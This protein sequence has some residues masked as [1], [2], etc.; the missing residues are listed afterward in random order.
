M[1]F[2]FSGG[3]DVDQSP[4]RAAGAFSP[5]SV[6]GASTASAA[7]ADVLGWN[8]GDHQGWAP[9]PADPAIAQTKSPR[10]PQCQEV[11]SKSAY[12]KRWQEHGGKD[13]DRTF[14]KHPGEA[15]PRRVP[16]NGCSP[17]PN[18]VVEEEQVSVSDRI[19]GRSKSQIAA[20]QDDG[21]RYGVA[22][23]QLPDINVEHVDIDLPK[24]RRFGEFSPRNSTPRRSPIPNH[25]GEVDASLSPRGVFAA[26]RPKAGDRRLAA[27]SSMGR[28]GL[29]ERPDTGT[30]PRASELTAT[31]E[32]TSDIA[33]ARRQVS[34][35]PE[36]AKEQG[37]AE[38]KAQPKLPAA[39]FQ[40]LPGPIP[41]VEAAANEA[42]PAAETQT[43]KR[44]QEP[45][46]SWR[47]ARRA[48]EK[49]SRPLVD[50]VGEGGDSRSKLFE[51]EA[52]EAAEQSSSSRLLLSS[53]SKS[54]RRSL[55][56]EVR[57]EAM[58]YFGSPLQAYAAM[59]PNPGATTV[60][61]RP[62]FSRKAA[63]Q[64]SPRHKDPLGASLRAQEIALLSPRSPRSPRL[65]SAQDLSPRGDMA[66][67]DEICRSNKREAAEVRSKNRSSSL[68][69][70]VF[71]HDEPSS[72]RGPG[73]P[74][75][76][77]QDLAPTKLTETVP[78]TCRGQAARLTLASAQSLKNQS[79]RSPSPPAAGVN[80]SSGANLPM[81]QP[82]LWRKDSHSE[83][84]VSK[85]S[86]SLMNS[87][88]GDSCRSS[89]AE[90]H[91]VSSRAS[92]DF[93]TNKDLA[94]SASVANKQMPRKAGVTRR[95]S[96]AAGRAYGGTGGTGDVPQRKQ[97]VQRS[98]SSPLFA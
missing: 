91:E 9:T 36:V 57:T 14:K 15:S 2:T 80:C 37:P 77:G 73:S 87:A 30:S 95:P 26:E 72:A 28:F 19:I 35:D 24:R 83:L 21:R 53:R 63:G 33:T 79:P 70:A 18:R 27:S 49:V 4:R 59:S 98:V 64:F 55:S 16:V 52:S 8:S 69:G 44:R 60:E 12:W 38:P 86:A 71:R 45:P 92:T 41:E 56:P 62:L 61:E 46:A 17:V 67:A 1:R 76:F 32:Q 22:S 23:E 94:D 7:L 10:H 68:M 78:G 13:I 96:L 47:P 90:L 43:Q 40:A 6:R 65:V 42:Q 75:R 5:N 66:T 85:S 31:S 58:Q 82:P 11:R 74:R 84:K 39:A 3:Q 34:W 50:P 51:G 97:I 54:P 25:H 88:A 93:P 20:P 48:S 29:E 81:W 89:R